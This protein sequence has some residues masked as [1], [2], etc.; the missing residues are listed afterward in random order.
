MDAD[1]DDLLNDALSDF[2]KK[3]TEVKV[4]VEGSEEK[5]NSPGSSKSLEPPKDVPASSPSSSTSQNVSVPPPSEIFDQFFDNEVSQRLQQEW[6]SAMK[7]LVNDDPEL[8]SQLKNLPSTMENVAS[9]GAVPS[10]MSSSS[11]TGPSGSSAGQQQASPADLNK[12]ME[13]TISGIGSSADELKNMTGA[14]EEEKLLQEMRNLGMGGGLSDMMGQMG[15]MEGM[16]NNFIS[17]MENMMENLLSKDVLYPTMKQISEVYPGWLESNKDKVPETDFKRYEQQSL[18]IVKICKNFEA[19]NENDTK[20]VKKQRLNELMA[21]V[22]KMQE[23]GNP[24]Q[25][26]LE[27]CGGETPMDMSRIFG[28]GGGFPGGGNMFGPDMNPENCAIM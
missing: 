26:L 15:D 25:E 11:N 19:D 8:A 1:L 3:P 4:R 28:A 2:D 20:E 6:E 23:C 9:G 18:V 27:K 22:E 7:E 10:A 21:L 5:K 14:T 13:D 12:V 24:P 17:M 16:E